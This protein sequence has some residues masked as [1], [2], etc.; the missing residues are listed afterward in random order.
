MAGIVAVFQGGHTAVHVDHGA[1][2]LH[3]ALTESPAEQAARERREHIAAGTWHYVKRTPVERTAAERA[4]DIKAL[5]GQGDERRLGSHWRCWVTFLYLA[6]PC[7]VVG[8]LAY[9]QTLP[10]S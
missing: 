3:D 1:H 2:A 10:N 7:A 8:A 6:C 5:Q 9:V 4:A